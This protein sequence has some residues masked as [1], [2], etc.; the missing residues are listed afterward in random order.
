MSVTD[1]TL[2]LIAWWGAGLSTLLAIIKFYE[3]WRDLSRVEIS[4][5]FTG[6]V[7][8]G[9]EVFIRNLSNRP[10]ILTYWELL[11]CSGR[12]PRRSFIPIES[13]DYDAGDHRVEPYA[14]H[15]LHFVKNSYFDWGDSKLNGRKIFILL[16][17]AGRKPLLKL[18]YSQ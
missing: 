15:T 7:G 16:H 18:V 5:N 3:F 4:Y 6:D 14:T 8:I 13:A 17:I 9:N 11:N 12:W 1:S 10:F 2:G